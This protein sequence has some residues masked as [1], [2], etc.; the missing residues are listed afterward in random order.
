MFARP[1]GVRLKRKLAK[2]LPRLFGR[3]LPGGP[4]GLSAPTNLAA[5]YVQDAP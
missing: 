3:S 4:A 1:I 5:T 2:R